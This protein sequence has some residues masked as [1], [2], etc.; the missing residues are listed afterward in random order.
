MMTFLIALAFTGLTAQQHDHAAMTK[1]TAG[2][3]TT[4][5]EQQVGQLLA[6]EGMGLAKP[7]ELNQYPGPRHVLELASDLKLTD[8]QRQQVQA[9]FD[10]MLQR[11]KAL[12]ARIVDAERTLDA[13]FRTGH[14]D[15]TRLAAL[16]AA[17]ATLQ[18]ELRAVHLGAHLAIR[19][20][21]T[22]EQV[23]QYDILR[24]YAK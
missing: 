5:S 1:E 15:E 7:A 8:V 13:S 24:G 17:A 14:I 4:L 16:T 22:E 21:L 3:T 19:R 9:A 20:V 18:G 11:A 6:G 10:A 12:G 2:A 23:E